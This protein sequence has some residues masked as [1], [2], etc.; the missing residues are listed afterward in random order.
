MDCHATVCHMTVRRTTTRSA[1]VLATLLIASAL[2][3][4]CGGGGGG[5]SGIAAGPLYWAIPLIPTSA[6]R[7]LK[8]GVRNLDSSATTIVIQSYRPGGLTYAAPIALTLD[9]GDERILTLSTVLS[10]NA[11]AGGIVYVQ[12]PSRLVDVY[13]DVDVPAE[14]AAEASRAY[15]LPDLASPPPGPFRTGVN[16]TTLTT[17]VQFANASG[18]IVAM[19]VTAYEESTVDP[20]L[21]P[22]PHTVVLAPFASG[23]SRVFTPDALSGITGFVGSFLVASPSPVVAAA[24][25]DLAFDIPRVATADRTVSTSVFFGQDPRTVVPSY[26]DFAL[27]ARNDLD[28]ARTIQ[29]TR[30]SR[31]DGT[32]L[33]TATRTISLAAHES[34][35]IATTEAPFADLLGD[36]LAAS[37]FQR[38]S[39]QLTVPAGVDVG[40]RQFEPQFLAAN[41]TLEPTPIGHI[42]IVSDVRTLAVLPSLVRSYATVYNPGNVTITVVAEALVP[43]PAGFDA[44]IVPIS[45]LT[46]PA[47]GQVEFSPDGTTYANRDLVH[48]DHVG[49]RLRSNA[50]LSVAARR[51]TRT[52]AGAV[53]TLVPLPVRSFDDGE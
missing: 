1:T 40:F 3:V 48:V 19:T 20:L 17:S 15:A 43:Q 53:D 44:S 32:A 22:V 28:V 25:E 26:L 35:A 36:V 50:A 34:R 27:V 12:T 31:D 2:V 21:P 37:A 23:E 49:L 38:L 7:T 4:G 6:S 14:T 9:A 46:I 39:I 33:F 5:G 11:A 16:V 29:L 41:M 30:I 13:F 18:G 24:E 8:V 42:L 52:A 51:E 45:T 47:H 10:G